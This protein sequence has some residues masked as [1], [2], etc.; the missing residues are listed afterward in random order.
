MLSGVP[1]H[2][3]LYDRTFSYEQRYEKL[4]V[5]NQEALAA[6]LFPALRIWTRRRL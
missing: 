4:D 1:R 2:S 3:N 6:P 5:R